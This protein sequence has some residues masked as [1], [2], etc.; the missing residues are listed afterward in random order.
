[1]RAAEVDR[2][3]VMDDDKKD[4]EL[5]P[6]IAYRATCPSCGKMLQGMIKLA[7]QGEH[8]VRCPFCG[9]SSAAMITIP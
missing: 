7:D 5:V 9:E 1:M 2:I 8:M 4:A 6:M 3:A